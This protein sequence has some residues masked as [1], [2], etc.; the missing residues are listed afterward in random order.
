MDCLTVAIV[1]LYFGFGHTRL[2]VT[3]DRIGTSPTLV[4][5]RWWNWL[6][7]QTFAT[8]IGDDHLCLSRIHDNDNSNDDDDD[9]HPDPIL[10]C[11]TVTT[12]SN[13]TII[14]IILQKD[15]SYSPTTLRIV[16]LFVDTHL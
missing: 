8:S 10:Q 2:V 1:Q 11:T 15:G 9:T 6:S 16:L 3:L 4:H 5:C 13:V 12:Q 7:H 14:I